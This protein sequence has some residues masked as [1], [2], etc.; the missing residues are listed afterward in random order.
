MPKRPKRILITGFDAFDKHRSNP[1]ELL[2]GTLSETLTEK[3]KDSVIIETLVLPTCCN[4][5]WSKLRRRLNSANG[6]Y[7]TIIMTGLAHTRTK[8][9]LERFALNIRDYRVKDNGG[10]QFDDVK[11]ERRGPDALRT[12]APLAVLKAALN[13]KGFPCDISNHAGT[14]I[15]NEIYYRALFHQLQVG[16]DAPVLFVH[17]PLPRTYLRTLRAGAQGRRRA[18]SLNGYSAVEHMARGIEA[19]ALL[20]LRG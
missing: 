8:L 5:A 14:F 2:V 6:D 4:K 18:P 11:I 9:S 1:S 15:C 3:G 17:I 10:H 12:I 16:S 7:S 20:C 19:A 13:R